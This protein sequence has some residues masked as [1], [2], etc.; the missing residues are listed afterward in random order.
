VV[1]GA[2]LLFVS[3]GLLAG[4]GALLWADQTQREGDYLWTDSSEITTSRYA[5]TS[6]SIELDTDGNDW[7][8][9]DLLGTA[10]LEVTPGDPGDELF[11]GVADSGDVDAYLS[12]VGHHRLGDLGPPWGGGRPGPGMTGVDGGPPGTT[13]GELDIWVAES[14]GSGTQTVDWRPEDGDWT[15]VMMRADGDAGVAVQARAG[16]T[17]PGLPWLAGGLL[18]SGAVMALVGA[19]FVV[20]AVRGAQQRPPTRAASEWAPPAPRGPTGSGAAA[21][22]HAPTS[23]NDP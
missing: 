4:G 21:P 9:D 2:V 16:A 11:V 13:P 5:L 23:R 15:V 22:T 19:L 12:G 17:V 18:V 14:T 3:T 1:L 20:L 8:V 10:R 7:V 6:D